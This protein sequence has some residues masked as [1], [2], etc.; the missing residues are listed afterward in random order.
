MRAAKIRLPDGR[1]SWTVL[2]ERAEPVAPVRAWLLHLEQIRLSPSTVERFAKHVAELGE[3]LSA[4]EKAFEQITVHDYDQFGAWFERRRIEGVA[5]P[6]LIPISRPVT[7]RVRI[8]ASLRNQAHMA[9][10]SFYRYLTNNDRF[11]FDVQN[12]LRVYD[13]ERTYGEHDPARVQGLA[14]LVQ[15][16]ADSGRRTLKRAANEQAAARGGC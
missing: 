16:A 7:A 11:E 6:K 14:I 8:S 4:R 10:K 3:F 12:K 9:V 1:V 5:S 2:D 15:A 13:R